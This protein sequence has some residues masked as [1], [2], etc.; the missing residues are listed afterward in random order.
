MDTKGH[1]E[2]YYV[3][4]TLAKVLEHK[5]KASSRKTYC[6]KFKAMIECAG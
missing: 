1:S 3:Y 4:K 2:Q 5:L 6:E